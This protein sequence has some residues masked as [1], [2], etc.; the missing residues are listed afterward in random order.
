MSDCRPTWI[1]SG[2][3]DTLIP[4]FTAFAEWASG[5]GEH[6]TVPTP[7]MD[8]RTPVGTVDRWTRT[9][10]ALPSADLRSDET[11]EFVDVD[12]ETS[13]GTPTSEPQRTGASMSRL[14][15]EPIRCRGS[16]RRS[17]EEHQTARCVDVARGA[18]FSCI[19][20]K[21]DEQE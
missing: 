14:L 12:G 7:L 16:H 6:S 3:R 15:H 17:A 4:V 9:Q 2:G 13:S 1:P 5:G 8:V 21:F 11:V 19:E 20:A 18:R 10:I